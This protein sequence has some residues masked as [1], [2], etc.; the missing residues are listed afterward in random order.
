MALTI[1]LFTSC[2]DNSSSNE[3]LINKLTVVLDSES[4][5]ASYANFKV[6]ITELKSG[7][8]TKKNT[9]ATGVVEFD[10]TAGAYDIVAEELVNGASTYFGVEKNITISGNK[11]ISIKVLKTT[12]SL[13]KT[14]ILDELYFNGD[15]NE[16]DFMGTMYEQYFTIR[17]VS[18]RALFADG[19]SF[20]VTGNYNNLE[21]KN[22]MSELLPETVVISQFYTIPGDGTTYKVEPNE[23]L[24]I[25]MSARNHK[26]GGIF[27][28]DYPMEYPGGEKS[29]D[30]SGADFEIYV[31]GGMTPDNPEVPNVTVNFSTFQAFHWQYSGASPMILFRLNK[32]ADTFISESKQ[33]FQNPM[34]YQEQDYLKLPASLIIDAVETGVIDTHFGN[35]LPLS[36][37]KNPFLVPSSGS[38]Q[39][40]FSGHLIKRK[41]ITVNGVETIQDTNNSQEDYVLLQGGNDYPAK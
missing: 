21:E 26:E 35:V 22:E 29:L 25:A 18:D 9:D 8:K 24:V 12:E 10:V 27:G 37:D 3:D 17:N 13:E 4:E 30:L 32:D 41:T 28:S 5:I 33:Q 15:M 6:T 38:F 14:F 1:N 19:L 23:S 11:E 2:S 7:S 31:Q 40:G 39:E 20:G 34:G 16:N 36:V